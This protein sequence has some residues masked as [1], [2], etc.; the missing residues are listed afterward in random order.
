[1]MMSGSCRRIVRSAVAK[2]TSICGVTC[3]WQKRGSTISMGSSTVV[4]L[5]SGPD[6]YRRV[7]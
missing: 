7:E 4:M 2:V 3:T 5:I 1:M 6:R